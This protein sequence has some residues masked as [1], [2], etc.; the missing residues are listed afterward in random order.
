[1]LSSLYTKY[2]G[3]GVINVKQK[4]HPT[5]FAWYGQMYHHTILFYALH[6]LLKGLKL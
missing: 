5:R 4:V 2:P 3:G 1:M 6:C